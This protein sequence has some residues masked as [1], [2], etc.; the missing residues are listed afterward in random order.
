MAC[1]VS[2][3]DLLLPHQPMGVTKRNPRWL[4]LERGITWGR[5]SGFLV[6]LLHHP[7][8]PVHLFGHSARC[9]SLLANRIGRDRGRP[10]LRRVVIW[11]LSRGVISRCTR[12]ILNARNALTLCNLVGKGGPI[13]EAILHL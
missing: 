4:G 13:F 8:H 11:M 6:G 10:P 12:Y 9:A 7:H 2:I 3:V 1:Q 5:V